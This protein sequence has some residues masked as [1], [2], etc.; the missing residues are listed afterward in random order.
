MY[1]FVFSIISLNRVHHVADIHPQIIG[2]M[3]TW[4]L[5]FINLSFCTTLEKN[6]CMSL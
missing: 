1:H 3:Q 2:N 4:P 5:V 6:T